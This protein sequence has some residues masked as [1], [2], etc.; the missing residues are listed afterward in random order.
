MKHG[1]RMPQQVNADS[2]IKNKTL[3]EQRLENLSIWHIARPYKT[4]CWCFTRRFKLAWR[5]F[6]GELDAIKYWEPK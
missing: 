5:V 6:I 3:V 4:T 2:F 1:I